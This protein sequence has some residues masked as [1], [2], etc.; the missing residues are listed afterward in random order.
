[1]VVYI[2]F[3]KA[4]L[5]GIA[6]LKLSADASL[7]FSVRNSQDQAEI[8]E[9][10]VVDPSVLHNVAISDHGKHRD[11]TPSHFALKWNGATQR[12]T[13]RVLGSSSE[14][15]NDPNPHVK[16]DDDKSRG[17]KPKDRRTSELDK[18]LERVRVM[19]ADDSGAMVPMLAL[20]CNGLEP[21]A[22]HPLGGEGEFVAVGKNGKVYENVD[23]SDG[24][25]SDYDLATGSV[26][27]TNFASAFQ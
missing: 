27:I 11:E 24:D 10:I 17:K 7:C 5:E 16:P 23:L 2:L 14:L 21:Y 18:A 1:M 26:S 6:S 9:K 12:A 19:E 15:V 25:W 3:C 13:L 4:D 22:F 20:D 8:R